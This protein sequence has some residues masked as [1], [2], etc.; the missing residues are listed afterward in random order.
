[1]KS[2]KDIH[3]CGEV[4]KRKRTHFSFETLY[5]QIENMSEL[6]KLQEF[7]SLQTVS[8]NGTNINDSGLQYVSQ[9]ATITNLNL[10]FTNIT[11]KGIPHLVNLKKLQWL[12]LK[13]TNISEKSVPYFNQITGLTSLQ[14]HETE[15]SGKDM[16]ILNLPN[17]EELLVDCEDDLDYETLLHLS[18]KLPQC[19]IICKGKGV[20][21]NGNFEF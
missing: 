10:T 16:A 8:L 1:M 13:E 11:D 3:I 17:L 20:F 18:K 9:C 21:R 6:K 15:I 19:E 12:R 14:I 4:F 2:K 5:K 7:P